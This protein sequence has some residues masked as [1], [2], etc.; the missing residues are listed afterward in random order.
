MEDCMYK[1]L[2][3]AVILNGS[4]IYGDNWNIASTFQNCQI[5]VNS[6]QSDDIDDVKELLQE[7]EMREAFFLSIIASQQR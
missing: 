1:K 5:I 3:M 7:E 2:M 6:M 4:F